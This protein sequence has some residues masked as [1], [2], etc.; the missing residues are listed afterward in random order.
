MQILITFICLKCTWGLSVTD[1]YS[2][3]VTCD[4]VDMIKE[5]STDGK[6]LRQIQ[7][8]QDVVSPLH[9]IQLP[10]G[11]FVVCDRE[12]VYDGDRV[13]SLIGS[14]GYVVVILQTSSIRH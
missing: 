3:L 14:Y 6:Q 7:L 12:N 8:S 2:V 1:T 11:Q 13:V 4:E 5:F 10:S 9:T